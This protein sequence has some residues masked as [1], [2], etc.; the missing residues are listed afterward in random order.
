MIDNKLRPL[1]LN[2]FIGQSHLIKNLSVFINSAKKRNESLDHVL[3][4]G[5][6]GLGKTTLAQI[7]ANEMNT[8]FI[9]LF[10]PHITKKEDL[11][12]ILL[13]IKENDILFIDEIHSLNKKIEEVLY[14]ALEDKE[15]DLIIDSQ[16]TKIKIK[17]FTLIGATTKPGN[18]SAPLLTRFSINLCFEF[19]NTLDLSKVVKRSAYLF[20]KKI[21]EAAAELVAIRGR[22]TPRIV[23]N[24]LRR[25][26]DFSFESNTFEINE[27]LCN[28]SFD[29]LKIDSKGLDELDR[30]ILKTIYQNYNNSVGLSS[31]AKSLSLDIKTIENIYEPFLI[32][33]NFLVPTSLGR[34][35]SDEAKDYLNLSRNKKVKYIPNMN[36]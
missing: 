17:N 12:N 3:L 19:Y 13:A 26:I 1:N 16:P 15:I 35:I 20:N 30:K 2:D 10:A 11:V 33:I 21:S 31:L 14:T 32:H 27:T 18:L 24:L 36:F 34:T 4:S 28:H 29:Q 5:P 22:G 6:A 7:I 8:N 25:I 9:H 23:N